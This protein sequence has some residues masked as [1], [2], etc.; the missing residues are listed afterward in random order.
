[1]ISGDKKK[2][3]VVGF[4]VTLLYSL[5]FAIPLYVNSIM[6]GQFFSKKSLV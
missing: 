4:V 1:M 3:L 2:L 5:H 6:L